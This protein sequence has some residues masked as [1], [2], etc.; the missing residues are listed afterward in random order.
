M[1]IVTRA[2]AIQFI[3]GKCHIKKRKSYKTALSDYY[4]CVSCDLLL[5][6]WGRT[7]TY[8]QAHTHP[9][10]HTHARAQTYRRMN[11][12]KT[13]RVRPSAVRLV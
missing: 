4:A 12:N 11:N 6:P 2:T 3:D 7:H 5:M 9:R 1:C 13:R 10:T 8:I